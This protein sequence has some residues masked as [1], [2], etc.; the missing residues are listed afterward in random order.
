MSNPDFAVP[1]IAVSDE[2]RSVSLPEVVAEANVVPGITDAA[3]VQ[4]QLFEVAL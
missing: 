4:L 1:A 2:L 3:C